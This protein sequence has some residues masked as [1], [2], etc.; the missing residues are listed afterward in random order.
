MRFAIDND[1]TVYVWNGHEYPGFDATASFYGVW[2]TQEDDW[3]KIHRTYQGIAL[4]KVLDQIN[5]A[6]EAQMS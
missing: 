6:F 4:E 2:I 3:Q 1:L 5:K